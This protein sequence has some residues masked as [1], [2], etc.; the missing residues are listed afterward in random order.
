MARLLMVC[1]GGFVGTGMRYGLNGW[2]SRKFG[3]TFPWGT[4]VINVSGSFAAGIAFFL[5]GPDSPMIVSA[6]TRQ[7]IIAGLLGGFTTFSSFS[8]QTLTLLREGEVGAALGNIV[9]S[10]VAGLIAAWLGFTL[11]RSLGG[12][13]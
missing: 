6:T 7:V 10:V 2:V 1:L 9:G 4:L 12:V 13:R 11:A 3:E 8:L 5:T